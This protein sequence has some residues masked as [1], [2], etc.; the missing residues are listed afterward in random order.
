M[1]RIQLYFWG[2]MTDRPL[3]MSSYHKAAKVEVPKWEQDLGISN[4]FL[5]KKGRD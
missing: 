2:R 3:D 5:W 4:I 1:G